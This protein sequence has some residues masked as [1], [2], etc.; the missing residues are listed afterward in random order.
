[1]TTV[2]TSSAHQ[3]YYDLCYNGTDY[4]VPGSNAVLVN[5]NLTPTEGVVDYWVV[6]FGDL[7]RDGNSYGAA[8]NWSA[9][10]YNDEEGLAVDPALAGVKV[11]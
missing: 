4:F 11:F 1:M 2:I 9:I 6:A 10:Y 7:D 3:Y 8:A 5:Y